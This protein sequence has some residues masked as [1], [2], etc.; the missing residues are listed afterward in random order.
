[1]TDQQN[2]DPQDQQDAEAHVGKIHFDAADVEGHLLKRGEPVADVEGHA[3]R[4]G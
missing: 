4:W 1:M 3:G 2:T